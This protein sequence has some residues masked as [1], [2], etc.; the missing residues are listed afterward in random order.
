MPRFGSGPGQAPAWCELEQF[1][2]V[3]LAPGETHRFDRRGSRELIIVA[4]GDCRLAAGDAITVGRRGV[5]MELPTAA[6][7]FVVTDVLRPTKLVRMA[8][9]WS[10]DF[11]GAGLF[12]V[13]EG[14][15][16]TQEGDPVDYPKTTRFD[17]HYHDL[18]EHWIF[19]EG[20]GVVYSEGRRYDVG[21]G[22][23]IATGVG[24]HHDVADTLDPILR[25]VWLETDL[26]RE[27]R[28]GHLWEHTHGAAVPDAERV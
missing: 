16:R 23:C 22:D 8:G 25:A 9:R 2:I 20:R 21:P 7:A 3:D 12:I 11:R 17:N 1:D 14:D 6:G 28:P 18:D 10:A 27:K 13:G 26:Q 19:Y 4:D 5:M 15:N 24:H